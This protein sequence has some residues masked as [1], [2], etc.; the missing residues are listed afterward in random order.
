M[1]S[2]TNYANS[3]KHY[4]RYAYQF[5]ILNILVTSYFLFQVKFLLI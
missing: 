4:F 5:N 1:N 2:I 3:K